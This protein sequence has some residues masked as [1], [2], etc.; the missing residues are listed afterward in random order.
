MSIPSV[1]TYLTTQIQTIPS[2]PSGTLKCIDGTK[3]GGLQ[4]DFGQF[5]LCVLTLKHV[6]GMDQQ[7]MGKS[8]AIAE[9]YAVVI[10]I[11]LGDEQCTLQTAMAR[12]QLFP[13]RL[14]AM[15]GGDWTL[16]GRCFNCDISPAFDNL[17]LDD[18]GQAQYQRNNTKPML[19]WALMVTEY[20]A[21][22][23]AANV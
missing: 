5:P 13:D 3:I 4:L 22:N 16:G 15:F 14:R 21:A 7:T 1:V 2:T 6:S 10:S 8:G 19:Q 9:Q 23:A 18:R 17:D 11:F 20:I 12:A